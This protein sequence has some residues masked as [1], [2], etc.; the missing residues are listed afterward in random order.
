MVDGAGGCVFVATP[1]PTI[2]LP[3]LLSRAISAAL[4]LPL[5]LPLDAL[6]AAGTTDSL[7]VCVPHV[8]T[9]WFDQCTRQPQLYMINHDCTR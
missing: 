8:L 5:V 9:K 4:C 6:F 7:V 3:A 1:P 2:P